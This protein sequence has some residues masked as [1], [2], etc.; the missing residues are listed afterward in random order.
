MPDDPNWARSANGDYLKGVLVLATRRHALSRTRTFPQ[1]EDQRLPGCHVF[2]VS[3]VVPHA[4]LFVG[5]P[6]ICERPEKEAAPLL[7]LMP[8]DRQKELDFNQAAL[9]L[10]E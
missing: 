10:L 1:V 6:I 5:L 4:A 3:G 9:R 7:V 8:S 2:T